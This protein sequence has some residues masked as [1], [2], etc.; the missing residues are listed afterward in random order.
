MH[1]LKHGDSEI[2]ACSYIQF[3]CGVCGCEFE[4]TCSEC[5]FDKGYDSYGNGAV[6]RTLTVQCPDCKEYISERKPLTDVQLH[7]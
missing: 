1:I 6:F 4:C 2:I 3:T 5:E 7:H